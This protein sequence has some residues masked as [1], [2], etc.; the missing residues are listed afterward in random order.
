M[1]LCKKFIGCVV[2]KGGHSFPWHW[3]R[4]YVSPPPKQSFSTGFSL[5]F[6]FLLYEEE[7]MTE[8]KI[9]AKVL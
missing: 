7:D 5:L 1:V 4:M 2:G 6:Q 3:Q 8:Y 9:A